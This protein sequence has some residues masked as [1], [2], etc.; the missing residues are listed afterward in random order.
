MMPKTHASP[1]RHGLAPQMVTILL[2]ALCVVASPASSQSSPKADGYRWVRPAV[3]NL[4]GGPGTHFD[5]LGQLRRGDR[6]WLIHVDQGWA[7]VQIPADDGWQEGW[8]RFDL[9]VENDSTGSVD[10]YD[11]SNDTGGGEL[12]ILWI[13]TMLAIVAVG[14]SLRSPA[15]KGR[16]GEL[17]V[18]AVGGLRLNKSTYRSFHNLTLPTYDGTTQID[19]VIVSK[20]GVFVIE[21][22]NMKGWIFGDARSRRWTQVIYG[23]KYPF[24]NPLN[25]NYKHIKAVENILPLHPRCLHSVVVFVGDSTFKTEMPPNVLKRGRLIRY[26]KS[27]REALL[28][29]SEVEESVRILAKAQTARGATRREHIEALKKNRRQPICPRCGSQMVLRTAMQ[30]RNAGGQ[31]WGCPSYPRCRATKDVA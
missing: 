5:V 29:D 9:L 11:R 25:Q 18:Q 23:K 14:A 8:I 24:Q 19:H 3:V 6:V 16:I 22:K 13:L 7:E 20:F 10:D 2:F 1:R 15:T 21:T 27:K 12:D 28:S 30:G 17:K 26:I 4:R 31:F